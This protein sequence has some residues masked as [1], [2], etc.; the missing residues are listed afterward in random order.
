MTPTGVSARE[1]QWQ[2]IR[3]ERE[4]LRGSLDAMSREIQRLGGEESFY[5]HRLDTIGNHIQ[6]LQNEERSSQ[7]RLLHI[8]KEIASMN[9]DEALQS[10]LAR[11][12]DEARRH[13]KTIYEPLPRIVDGYLADAKACSE[14]GI[15]AERLC[16]THHIQIQNGPNEEFSTSYWMTTCPKCGAEI[17]TITESAR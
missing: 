2:A 5:R 14:C 16:W 10:H 9:A 1:K 4:L 3:E 13:T 11:V 17:D 6:I 7:H 8:E 12:A 15:T